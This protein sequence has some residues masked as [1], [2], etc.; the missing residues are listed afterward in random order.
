[1]I[2]PPAPRGPPKGPRG[3]PSKKLEKAPYREKTDYKPIRSKPKTQVDMGDIIGAIA[4]GQYKL[5]KVEVGPHFILR[6]S[7]LSSRHVGNF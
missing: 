1:M 4:Q 3:G 7:F 2:R 5:K 6:S